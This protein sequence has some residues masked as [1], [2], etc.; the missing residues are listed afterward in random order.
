MVMLVVAR[1]F[2][3]PIQ[4]PS[5]SAALHEENSRQ[6]F[7]RTLL[8]VHVGKTGGETIKWRLRVI[9]D[10]RASKRKKA[11]CQSMFR[12]TESVLSKS[13]IGYMHCD[14]I[15]P[16]ESL[17]QASTFLFGVRD[18]ID[19]VVS[20]YQYMHPANCLSSQPSAACNLKKDNNPWGR[21]FYKD[22]FPTINDL[23]R[24]ISY[25]A[26]S[27]EVE[28]DAINTNST[29]DVCA[30]LAIEAL[31][32]R[33]PEGP[34]NHLYFNYVYLANRTITQYPDKE[35]MVVRQES[36]WYDLQSIEGV[37]GGNSQR[38]FEQQGPTITHGSEKFSHR[39]VLDEVIARVGILSL[40]C[41]LYDEIHTY[42]LILERAVNLDTFQ[43][44]QTFQHAMARC[45][46]NSMQEL[47]KMCM[48][49]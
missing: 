15:R 4:K 44:Q 24:S 9:C 33:G 23:I 34:T 42:A 5:D 30:Q 22:C 37:I 27:Q 48:I 13:T 11:R 7:N 18:P 1:T 39:A 36:L 32:G 43:K 35:V 16:R 46:V 17:H 2:T 49:K 41:I 19:R 3:L 29:S 28:Q 10:Q 26:L 40:C 6:R 31:Q 45:D 25:P 38:K 47:H 21:Q 12:D 14:K 20:W 8:F